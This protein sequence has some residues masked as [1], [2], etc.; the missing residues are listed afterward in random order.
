MTFRIIQ[1]PEYAE[2]QCWG[3]SRFLRVD[4]HSCYPSRGDYPTKGDFVYA[5]SVAARDKGWVVGWGEGDDVF[6]LCPDCVR[7]GLARLLR[8][9]YDR[10]RESDSP[11]DSSSDSPSARRLAGARFLASL[12]RRVADWLDPQ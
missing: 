7:K 11:P 6:A 2:L 4:S 5:L 9:V 10:S 3:C 8:P 1:R 12:L